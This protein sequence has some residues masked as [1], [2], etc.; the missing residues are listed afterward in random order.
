MII[1]LKHKRYLLVFAIALGACAGRA[2]QPVAVVQPQ[3]SYT[4]C[5]AIRAEIEANNRRASE[6]AS[7][8]GVKVVQNV[9]AGVAGIFVPVLWFGMDWQGT[10]SDEISALQS[11]QQYLA[12]LAGQRCAP[13]ASTRR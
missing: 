13:A 2:P 5:P 6:L 12:T 9:A 1:L 11:R 4:D 3:D 8:K 7:E 10:A